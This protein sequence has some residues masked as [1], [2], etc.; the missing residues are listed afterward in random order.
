[1]LFLV[2]FLFSVSASAATLTLTPQGATT[3]SVIV[4]SGDFVT[5]GGTG[6]TLDDS[7]RVVSDEDTRMILTA[8]VNPFA[9]LTILRVRDVAA[10][11]GP[12]LPPVFI[13][14][15][16][17]FGIGGATYSWNALAGDVYKIRIQLTDAAPGTDYDLRVETPVPAAAFLFAPALVGFMALRRRKAA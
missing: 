12:A 2:A 10:G 14:V 5:A 17:V 15:S 3:G 8:T 13:A 11:P 7:F 16:E 6:T 1:M 4:G 9:E